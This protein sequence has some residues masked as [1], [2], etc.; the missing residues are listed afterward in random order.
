MTALTR[1]GLLASHAV[2]DQIIYRIPEKKQLAAAYYRNTIVHYFLSP[3]I[4]ELA[5]A[6]SLTI[7]GAS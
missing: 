7:E 3:A 2:G 6:H 1:T 4:A 5:L